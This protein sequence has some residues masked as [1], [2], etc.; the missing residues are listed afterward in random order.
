MIR[1]SSSQRGTSGRD[2]RSRGTSSVRRSAF[3]K[4][5]LNS[6]GKPRGC[7]CDAS[8]EHRRSARKLSGVGREIAVSEILLVSV[9]ELVL[10]DVD[11]EAR[12]LDAAPVRPIGDRNA[13]G[14]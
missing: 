1:A 5:T 12:T 7:A 11:A 13:L 4:K 10:V 6:T 3:G 2:Q 9:G 8:S 14:Q